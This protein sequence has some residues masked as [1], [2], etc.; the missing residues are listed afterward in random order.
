MNTPGNKLSRARKRKPKTI[1]KKL[2]YKLLENDDTCENL[3]PKF[4]DS[5][6]NIQ[7]NNLDNNDIN[8]LIIKN[9]EIAATETL[10]ETI[11][12]KLHQPWQND[13]KLRELYSK[14]DELFK[15]NANPK[16][17]QK[18]RKQICKRSRQLRNEHLK[19]EAEKLDVLAATRELDKL[20]ITAK[21]QTTTLNT[22]S[23]NSSCPPE[24]TF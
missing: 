20:F 4:S 14:K 6:D 12:Q 22:S 24:K 9:I 5:W 3:I 16:D 17:V 23:S 15:K 13:E 7:I 11:E 18:L 2:N 1:R 21:R 10:P 8:D 19:A